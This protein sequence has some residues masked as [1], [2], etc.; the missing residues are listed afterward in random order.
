MHSTESSGFC[1]LLIVST[2]LHCQNQTEIYKEQLS[3]W[4]LVLKKWCGSEHDDGTRL[5]VA[6]GVAR[7]LP[8]LHSHPSASGKTMGIKIEVTF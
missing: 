2:V 6:E 5:A 3:A 7:T 8:F 1:I 4:V